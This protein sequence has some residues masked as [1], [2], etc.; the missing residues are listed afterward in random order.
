[1]VATGEMDLGTT[2]EFV[3]FAQK[4]FSQGARNI[5]VLDSPGGHLIEGI[6]L[7]LVLRRLN[8]TIFVGNVVER[9]DRSFA[10]NGS[11]MSACV[12]AL[13]GGRRRFVTQGSHVGVHRE[14]LPGS[15]GND[16]LSVLRSQR[17]FPK[18]T[19]F[20]RNYTRR[21]GVD[22]ALVDLAEQYGAGGIRILTAEDLARFRLAR[23]TR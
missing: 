19:E 18:I 7:G 23:I 3:R 1:M 21:M 10:A 13:M 14:L 9:G 17:R 22:P 20:V 12:Y 8:T 6:K 11:C 16:P 2:Q 5:L 15:T 4:S